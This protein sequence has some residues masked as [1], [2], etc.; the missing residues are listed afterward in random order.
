M[1]LLVVKRASYG[2]FM[3]TADHPDDH[4]HVDRA[5]IIA[6][7]GALEDL[8]REMERHREMTFWPLTRATCVTQPTWCTISHSDTVT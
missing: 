7:L 6:E 8:I 5:S 2:E 1:A 4:G 3:G